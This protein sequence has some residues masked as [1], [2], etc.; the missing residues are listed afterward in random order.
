MVPLFQTY[1]KHQ[2]NLSIDIDTLEKSTA[3]LNPTPA[4]MNVD[5]QTDAEKYEMTSVNQ[6]Y[7]SVLS[8]CHSWRSVYFSNFLFRI[9]TFIYHKKTH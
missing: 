4:Y 7:E 9:A 3:V 1:S 6:V 5:G 8:P 2:P